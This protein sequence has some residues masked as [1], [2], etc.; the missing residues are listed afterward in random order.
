M[1][2]ATANSSITLIFRSVQEQVAWASPVT[3]I[4][5]A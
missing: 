3:A 5:I 1:R 4:T 2:T